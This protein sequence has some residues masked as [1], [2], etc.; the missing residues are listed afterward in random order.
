MEE[1][2]HEGA[3]RDAIERALELIR[4]DDAVVWADRVMSHLHAWGFEV[5]KRTMTPTRWHAVN[6]ETMV[7]YPE[8]S[9]SLE[10]AAD[11]ED[12]YKLLCVYK[13]HEGFT[14][15]FKYT[16]VDAEGDYE[17]DEFLWTHDRAEAEAALAEYKRHPEQ[18]DTAAPDAFDPGA[19]FEVPARPVEAPVAPGKPP[20][21]PRPLFVGGHT[22]RMDGHHT[23]TTL[24]SGGKVEAYPED[25]D[26][27]KARAA[28]LGYGDDVGRM[29]Q[30]HEIT[31]AL[32]AT[33]L[34]LPESPTFRNVVA[35]T[36][37]A[38]PGK[39]EEAAILGIQRFA[40]VM[41]VD[42]LRV[43]QE[44]DRA[45]TTKPGPDPSYHGL[46]I[47]TKEQPRKRLAD[48]PFDLQVTCNRVA[49]WAL[50]RADPPHQRRTLASEFSDDW[51]VL[52]F[53]GVV[54]C[55]GRT[56]EGEPS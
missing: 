9:E 25:N 14:W 32:L 48:L 36:P 13:A 34:G 49:G 45:T 37:Y 29:S 27:Y 19:R 22:I 46:Y 23:I 39:D 18:A 40:R 26:E 16:I 52:D 41:G 28:A 42:L 31:H 4:P 43:A 12:P 15:G 5:I 35:G 51:L 3:P 53:E 10:D 38:K 21:G 17:G 1:D 56:Y 20:L 33:W 24:M 54:F 30:D 50:E 8:A 6:P 55:D 44:V 11:C 47:T 2:E 7:V